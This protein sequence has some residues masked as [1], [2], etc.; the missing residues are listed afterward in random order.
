MNKLVWRF[1]FIAAALGMVAF[2]FSL[3]GGENA[4]SSQMTGGRDL[5][6]I[7]ILYRYQ[8]PGHI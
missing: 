5:I 6:P 2:V 4:S 7:K 3:A 8:Y 1:C